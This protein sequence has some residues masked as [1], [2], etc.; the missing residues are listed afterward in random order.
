MSD[1]ME[2]IEI[3]WQRQNRLKRILKRRWRFLGSSF[4]KIIG[5]K[6]AVV[7]KKGEV[8]SLQ[9]LLPGDLVRVR[10]REEIEATLDNWNQL[11]RCSFVEEMVPYCNTTQRVFKRIEKFLDERDY[12]MKKTNSIVILQNV[13]CEGAK[14]F[15]ACDRTC[16]YF[17]REEWLEKIVQDS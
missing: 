13:F 6:Q 16:F 5:A 9:K 12:L 15:G 4:S 3:L 17:W 14:D 1:P 11:K 2:A 7:D 10:S 8:S